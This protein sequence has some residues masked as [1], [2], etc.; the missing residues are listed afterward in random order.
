MTYYFFGIFW[1]AERGINWCLGLLYG[2]PS[3]TYL[4]ICRADG[5]GWTNIW[6][7]QL[8]NARVSAR[9]GFC[10]SYLDMKSGK[11]E[12]KASEEEKGKWEKRVG[13]VGKFSFSLKNGLS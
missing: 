7:G 1:Q 4:P 11:R 10:V 3:K 5:E 8:P 13:D 12:R 9:S 2:L 6:E